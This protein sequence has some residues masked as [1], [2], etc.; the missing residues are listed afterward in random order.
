V[1]VFEYS[2]LDA[3]GRKLRGVA[4]GESDRHVRRQL[5]DSGLIPVSI[6][7]TREREAAR[8]RRLG[9]LR[10]RLSTEQLALFTR[11]LGSLLRS[12]LPLDDALTAMS[13]QAGEEKLRR[14]VLDV[15]AKV[16]EGHTLEAGLAKYP[17]VFA[18]P[19]RATVG[20]GEHTRHLPI[21]L[22]R[23]ADYVDQRGQLQSRIRLAL[24]YPAILTVTALLVVGALL[25]YVVPEVVRIFEHTSRELPAITRALIAISDWTE[26]FGLLALLAGIALG[27]AGRAFFSRAA[28]KFALHRVLLRLPVIGHLI[29]EANA[30]R[31]AR[32][33]AILLA[34]GVEMLDALQ[35]AAKGLTSLPIRD[36]V[37]EASGRVREGEALSVALKRT[38]ALPPMLL[39]LIASGESSGELELMLDT[40][41]ASHERAVHT[42]LTILLGLVEPALI[43]A[44][45]A[46]ILAVV[47]AILLPIFEINQLV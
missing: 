35:I 5:R 47:V 38:E 13:K 37:V 8:A 33:L 31:L 30:V 2:A 6:T 19:Y 43:L 29:R 4:E 27:F 28:P 40:A 36:A 45:G 44:M 41:A 32:T 46:M 1:T 17:S 9:F 16:L 42:T 3:A 21:V 26:R 10:P 39:H 34:S 25:T 15:R 12:G 14:I 22:E 20:A 7:E 24:I 23:L 11:L 18:E